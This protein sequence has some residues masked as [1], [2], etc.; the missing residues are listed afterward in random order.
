MAG[1]DQSHPIVKDPLNA[2]WFGAPSW[3]AKLTPSLDLC[4]QCTH[5]LNRLTPDYMQSTSRPICIF[6]EMFDFWSMGDS[7]V[8]FTDSR[9]TTN[10]PDGQSQQL[11]A[12]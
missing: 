2:S 1:E 8:H 9:M 12:Q 7:T 10:S 3:R 4:M 6:V 5:D 11:A